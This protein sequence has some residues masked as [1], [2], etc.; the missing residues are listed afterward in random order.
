[1]RAQRVTVAPEIAAA[2]ADRAAE[3]LLTL[4]QVL[5]AK[6]VALY[7]AVRG[8]ISTAPAALALRDRGVS[9]VYPRV[10]R[11]ERRLAFH[12][13]S[14]PSSMSP[15]AF[16]ILEPDARAPLIAATAIDVIVVPGL[17]FDAHG[18]R[19][20]WGHGYYDT[21]LAST[22]DALHVGYAFELQM[23]EIVPIDADDAAMD[24]VIT[25]AHVRWTPSSS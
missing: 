3:H 25:E 22:G 11:D 5:S 2:A 23:V 14:D 21:T 24:C 4:E 12:E 1:M 18:G 13:V 16:G 8:E 17:A 9:L 7:S 10:L 20:G 15:G 6:R 19:V